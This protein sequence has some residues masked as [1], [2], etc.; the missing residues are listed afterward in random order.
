MRER[1]SEGGAARWL[2]EAGP[3]DWKMLR[4]ATPALAGLALPPESRVATLNAEANECVGVSRVAWR[5][6]N[7]KIPSGGGPS[8]S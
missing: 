6:F 3:G 4:L 7:D 1:C 5:C 8:G 2:R